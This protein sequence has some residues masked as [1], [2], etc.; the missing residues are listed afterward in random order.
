MAAGRV[1]L[2]LVTVIL[3]TSAVP[4]AA[5]AEAAHAAPACTNQVAPS[6]PVAEQPWAQRRH[7][8]E[9][10]DALTTGAGVTVAVV[11]SGVDA[12]HPQ[13]SGQVL[14]GTDHLDRGGDG[15]LDCVGHGT[16]VAS[17]IAA[18]PV[19]GVAFRGLAPGVRILPVRISEQQ[20]IEG[21]ESGR[22]VSAARFAASIRG[23]VDAGA[24]VINLSVVLYQDNPAVRAAIAHAV[25]RDVVVVAAVGNLHENGDPRP[26]PAAYEGVLGVGAI[27]PD[28]VRQ[29]FSQVG[30]YVDLVAPG[31]DVLVAAPS[32][33]HQEQSGTSYAAPFVSAAAALVRAYRPDLSAAEVIDRLVATADPAPAGAGSTEYGNGVVNPYRAVTETVAPPRP[34]ESAQ[35]LPAHPDDAATLARLERRAA[36]EERAVLIA[37]AA[38]ALGVL[39]LLLALV[40]PRGDR[41]RWR[42]AG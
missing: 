33:G 3:A 38:A 21:R 37:A 30:A 13:L 20:V 11:D 27:G 31:G 40:L 15:R 36:A 17:I 12:S 9:G 18:K 42:S 7:P 4:V 22:T 8:A 41:R 19:D 39:V 2:V 5:R 6:E 16:A 23:A 25:A 1:P 34:V 14:R 35:P 26:Y 10:L 24:D 28:G 32:R 29:G